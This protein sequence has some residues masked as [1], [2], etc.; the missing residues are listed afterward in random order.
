MIQQIAMMSFL[1]KFSTSLKLMPLVAC[2][3]LFSNACKHDNSTE[4]K[5]V[6]F[7]SD[8]DHFWEAYD[9][10]QTVKDSALQVNMMQ[11]L[12]IDKGT[13]GLKA[14]MK[15]RNFDAAR[16]VKTIRAYPGFWKS[17]RQN[18]MVV[19]ERETEIN[20][21]VKEFKRLYPDYRT[22]RIYFTITAIRAGGTTQDSLVLVGSEIA[23]GNKYTDVSEFPDNRLKNF[24]S[25]QQTDNIVPFTIHEYV[26][27]QQ[28]REGTTLLGQCLAEG[29]CDLI[30]ELVLNTTLTHSYLVYG[31][32]H[33]DTLKKVFKEEMYSTDFANWLYNGATAE[34]VGDLGYFMGYTICKS[35]YENASD[36]NLAIKNI[37]ELDYADEEAIKAF[38][39]ASGYYK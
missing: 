18:T 37:I 7:T 33:E 13:D 5:A 36:K 20:R 35:Y 15:L 28:K 8:I 10:L 32:E 26:H 4:E 21:A 12:Y 23:T 11:R 30:T 2:I 19:K 24:F 16:I 27:T 31:R 34:T 39:A 3:L 25:T 17:I 14:F 6:V 38:L 22:A 29:S 9:S 1:K